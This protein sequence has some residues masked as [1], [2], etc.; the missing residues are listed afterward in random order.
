MVVVAVF[1]LRVLAI[2]PPIIP[3]PHAHKMVPTMATTSLV[4]G[5][6]M[7]CLFARS[8]YKLDSLQF[9]FIEWGLIFFSSFL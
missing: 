7:G 9:F 5:L 8:L 3:N 4:A 6:N 2:H 1:L